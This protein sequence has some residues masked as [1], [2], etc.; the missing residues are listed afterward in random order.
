MN[1]FLEN[2]PKISVQVPEK[3]RGYKG[4]MNFF[5]DLSQSCGILQA[6]SWNNHCFP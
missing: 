2:L 6:Y 1:F 3:E 4:N 5:R